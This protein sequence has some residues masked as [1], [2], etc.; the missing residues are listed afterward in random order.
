[1]NVILL[2]AVTF[3]GLLFLAESKTNAKPKKH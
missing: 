2:F 1:M 3:F